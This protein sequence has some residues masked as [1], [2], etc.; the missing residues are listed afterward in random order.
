MQIV[1]ASDRIG[2]VSGFA[3]TYRDGGL[4]GLVASTNGGDVESTIA[5]LAS[6]LKSAASASDSEVARA[7]AVLR[8][9]ARLAAGSQAGRAQA[10]VAA[11]EDVSVRVRLLRVRVVGACGAL[12]RA[13]ACDP[14]RTVVWSAA[15]CVCTPEPFFSQACVRHFVRRRPPC[16]GAAGAAAVAAAVTWW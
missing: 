16:G 14:Q 15:R 1:S 13:R 9:N 11:P 10:L 3:N 8:G 5:A 12:A 6:A 4:V 2:A 7:K